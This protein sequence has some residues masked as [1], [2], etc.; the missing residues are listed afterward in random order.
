MRTNK[1]K[2]LDNRKIIIFTDSPSIGGTEKQFFLLSEYLLS[3]YNCKVHIWNIT[4]ADNLFYEF[5]DKY[6]LPYRKI[7][8]PVSGNRIIQVIKIMILKFLFFLSNPDI[9]MSYLI[10]P[11]VYGGVS[12]R[13]I[14]NISFIWNQRDEGFEYDD[15]AHKYFRIAL[16]NIQCFI[17]NSRNGIKY[18][19][20]NDVDIKKC[21]LVKNGFEKVPVLPFTDDLLKIRNEFSFIVTMIGNIHENKDHTTLIK[22]WDVFLRSGINHMKD[23]YLL[24]LAGKEYEHSERIKRIIHELKLQRNIIFMGFRKD[25]VNILS[26]SDLYVHSSNSEGTSNALIEAMF[27][28]KAIVATNIP[29][30]V[31]TVSDSNHKYLYEKNNPVDLAEKIACLI[32]NPELINLLGLENK[33]YAE[34]YYKAQRMLDETTD[35]MIKC[36]NDTN[37]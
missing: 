13:G 21:H 5:V 28:G 6:R 8:Y 30:I 19:N 9:I 7:F 34:K 4:K 3:K 31:E 17:A 23:S 25:I 18:L 12:I 33:R 1:I 26:I 35:I 15:N 29:S 22:G 2:I 14:K 10:K 11:N 20:K 32:Q 36:M 27:A 24:M 37:R 16:N